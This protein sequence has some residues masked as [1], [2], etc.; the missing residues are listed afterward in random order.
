MKRRVKIRMKSIAIAVS[1]AA[2]CLIG[3]LALADDHTVTGNAMPTKVTTSCQSCHGPG[4]NSVSG[5]VP[6]L[7]GQQA[8]YI[9]KRLNGFLDPTHEDPHAMKSMWGVVSE[10]DN[11]TFDTLA[12]YY[13]G[14]PPTDAQ[15]RGPLVTEGRKIY[16]NG[17]AAQGV[18]ACQACHGAHAEG[19]GAVPRLAG[20]HADYLTKQL[21]RLRLSMRESDT[22]YHDIK[23]MTDSQIGEIV[24]FLA[25][26]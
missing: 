13:A 19:S 26:D 17:A 1:A 15:G 8:D 18:S 6:R 14:Q 10:I 2:T 22:M 4:G 20:Q 5:S 7:N 21:E 11:A 24:A 3:T 23:A 12:K 25:T 9:V 16:A